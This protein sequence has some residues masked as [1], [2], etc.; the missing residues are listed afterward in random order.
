MSKGV[1]QLI[2]G[3]GAAQFGTCQTAAGN[4]QPVAFNNFLFG[5]QAE[6]AGC[7]LYLFHFKAQPEIDIRLFQSKS[8]NIQHGI[9]LVGVR[10]YP[11]T[12]LCYGKQ[13]QAAEP[14]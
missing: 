7:F 14:I 9:G 10:V 8:Q 6:A 2:T 4:N 3:H 12:F 13:T 1:Q 5:F 11:T